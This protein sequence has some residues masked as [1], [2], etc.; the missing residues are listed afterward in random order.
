MPP[1]AEATE[2][3]TLLRRPSRLPQHQQPVGFDRELHALTVLLSFFV[4]SSS[5]SFLLASSAWAMRKERAEESTASPDA[6]ASAGRP[7]VGRAT[8]RSAAGCGHFSEAQ[9]CEDVWPRSQERS[10]QSPYRVVRHLLLHPV[11]AFFGPRGAEWC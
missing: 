11:L 4:R 1:S 3:G 8:L 10:L 2:P 7:R 6:P 9:V 5:S